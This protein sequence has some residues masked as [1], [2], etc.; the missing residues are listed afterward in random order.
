M[1]KDDMGITRE[2][3]NEINKIIFEGDFKTPTTLYYNGA[4]A[5]HMR[6]SG[7]HAV[8]LDFNVVKYNLDEF[9]QS[10]GFSTYDEWYADVLARSKGQGKAK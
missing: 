2:K 8:P 9:A 4:N 1:N 7:A 6:E 5:T 10:R 3:D